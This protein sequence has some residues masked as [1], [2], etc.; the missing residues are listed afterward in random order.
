VSNKINVHFTDIKDHLIDLIKKANKSIHI[1]MA[2]MTDTEIMDVILNQLDNGISIE[3]CIL[4]HK[5][6]RNKKE[7]NESKF[8][9]LKNYKADLESFNKKYGRIHIIEED[10]GFMHNK[11]A[12]IDE[13]IAV[14]GSY[15]WSFN[16]RNGLENIVI[17]E[18]REIASKFKDQ[19]YK[20]V[21]KNIKKIVENEFSQC[22]S[23]CDG[24]LLKIKILDLR[25]MTKFYQNETYSL[26]FCTNMEHFNLIDQ[27]TESFYVSEIIDEELELYNEE[28][29]LSDQIYNK[30]I[31][32]R[33]IN[34]RL[35]KL[36]GSRL[37]IFI[38]DNSAFLGIYKLVEN[39]EGYTDL[40][41]IW[42]HEILE[43]YGILDFEEEIKETIFQ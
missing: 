15:N 13:M 23:G 7:K 2:W 19:Y 28:I 30:T 20:I 38:E 27:Q 6:N 11:F 26:E 8:L 29:E 22:S 42:E 35:V 3:I 24:K 37:D 1:C 39:E 36:I 32:E 21:N 40:N 12:V 16:A 14:T 31:L 34:E 43:H 5:S 17:I 4:D 18:D 25:R 9:D 10:I 41:P 33:R